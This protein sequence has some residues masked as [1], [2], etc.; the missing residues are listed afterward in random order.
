MSSQYPYRQM[1]KD[2]NVLSP[3]QQ[4]ELKPSSQPLSSIA[5][6]ETP[7]IQAEIKNLHETASLSPG[8]MFRLIR[9]IDGTM[10]MPYAH[11]PVLYGLSGI[12]AEEAQENAAR[13]FAVIH[14]DDH[15]GFL[16]SLHASA[17]EMDLW[18]KEFRVRFDDGALFTLHARAVPVNGPDSSI[19]WHGTI[20]DLTN[21]TGR[22]PELHN[23]KSI[24]R[25]LAT[26]KQVLSMI[27]NECCSPLSLLASSA[28][29]ITRYGHE[30]SK[31]QFALQHKCILA[32][33]NQLSELLASVH[34]FCQEGSDLPAFTTT[35]IDCGAICRSIAQEVTARFGMKRQITM[36]IADD[37]G[38]VMMNETLFRRVLNSLLANALRFTPS[39]GDIIFQAVR[40]Q[41][42]LLVT[43]TD[44]GIGIP[45]EDMQRIFEPF[46]YASNAISYH[47]VGLGLFNVKS[48]LSQVGG[49]LALTSKPGEGTSAKVEIPLIAKEGVKSSNSMFSILII[50]NDRLLNSNMALILQLEGYKVRSVTDGSPGLAMIR[51]KRP[52]LILC[53]LPMPGGDGYA[54]LEAIRKDPE[55]SD[56]YFIYT[57]AANDG[58]QMHRGMSAGAD[59]FLGK[60]F[61][62]TDLLGTVATHLSKLK[63]IRSQRSTEPVA[64]QDESMVLLRISP[65]EREILLMVG[66]GLTSKEIAV[67]LFISL[68]TVEIHRSRLMKKLG[69]TNAVGLARWAAIAERIH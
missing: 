46:H 65:R 52:D 25:D 26:Q 27:T 13:I 24:N 60:P 35:M 36:A 34:A 38:M 21:L 63:T 50:E 67:R 43:I 32:V 8:L 5:N 29:I 47:G 17:H 54:F 39:D 45:E 37:C 41:T 62:H 58:T 7:E 4:T 56:I 40:E 6:R 55:F 44:S 19:I 16:A 9:R 57:M 28:D 66:H 12:T 23:E 14:P 1:E 33:S 11:N 61:C 49:T 10:A 51:D 64:S 42:R 31:D 20:L 22:Q 2:I 68:K 3:H 48:A 53:N 15:D 30:L 59:G 18:E 69:A